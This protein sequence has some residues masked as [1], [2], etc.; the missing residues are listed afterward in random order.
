MPSLLKSTENLVDQ[1]QPTKVEVDAYNQSQGH[2]TKHKAPT[3]NLDMTL[4]WK[5]VVQE[6]I[7][8]EGSASTN[9]QFVDHSASMSKDDPLIVLIWK[10]MSDRKPYK[11]ADIAALIQAVRPDLKALRI[12]N[13]MSTMK[14]KGWFIT[15]PAAGLT[16]GAVAGLMWRLKPEI[17]DPHS[18]TTTDANYKYKNIDK[19]E[20]EKQVMQIAPEKLEMPSVNTS[21]SLQTPAS[22]SLVQVRVHESLVQE[23]PLLDLTVRIKGLPLS[24]SECRQL[25]HEL[26]NLG[27]GKVVAPAQNSLV[28]RSITIK[29]T[30]F[31][32]PEL[33]TLIKGL[34]A[35]GLV[36]ANK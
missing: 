12:Q 4:G 10:A 24:L 8:V 11:S 31:S 2:E 26:R 25:V 19:Q 3:N 20:L 14:A 6:S 15:E 34:V 27:Y 9:S 32:E 18:Y 5:Q 22:K 35:E 28:N 7:S 1:T 17:V 21:Q 36:L 33:E 13:T 30:D 23:V 16:K 29:D